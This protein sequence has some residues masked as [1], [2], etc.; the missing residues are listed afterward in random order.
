MAWREEIVSA[1][2]DGRTELI[3]TSITLPMCAERQKYLGVGASERPAERQGPANGVPSETGDH[4]GGPDPL[5]WAARARRGCSP[6]APETGRRR[7]W[8]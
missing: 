6:K 5:R 8:R 4:T 1:G 3:C 7:E 2:S